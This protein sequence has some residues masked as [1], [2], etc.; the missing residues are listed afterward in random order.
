[1][2]PMTLSDGVEVR[3]VARRRHAG[4]VWAGV[5]LVGAAALAGCGLSESGVGVLV[6]DPSRYSA[7]HCKDL[8]ARLKVLQGREKDLRGLM[9]KASDGGGGAVIGT[10][11]YRSDYETVLSEEKLLQR[12]A[13]EKKCELVPTYQSDQTIR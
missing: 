11:A 8:I 2:G 4:L 13:A 9:D 3:T 6:V 5:L 7:Y 1:M 12:T 10:L